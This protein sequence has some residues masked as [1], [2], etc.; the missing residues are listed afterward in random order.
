[1]SATS[2]LL[3]NHTL[4]TTSLVASSPAWRQTDNNWCEVGEVLCAFPPSSGVLCG[5]GTGDMD[6]G[7][8]LEFARRQPG[9]QCELGQGPPSNATTVP[10]GTL[11]A[12]VSSSGT[13]LDDILSGRGTVAM[14][15]VLAGVVIL[16]GV[17]LLVVSGFS[18]SEMC[19]KSEEVIVF[20]PRK[21]EEERDPASHSTGVVRTVIVESL[22]V[23]SGV[24]SL[25]AKPHQATKVLVQADPD[26]LSCSDGA[27]DMTVAS[28]AARARVRAKCKGLSMI[29]SWSSLP[30]LA[31]IGGGLLDEDGDDVELAGVAVQRVQDIATSWSELPATRCIVEDSSAG[32]DPAATPRTRAE[33]IAQ[34]S[35]KLTSLQEGEG[36]RG[37]ASSALERFLGVPQADLAKQS[38]FLDL[39]ARWQ[40]LQAPAVIVG[41]RGGPDAPV[42]PAPSF[43]QRASENGKPPPPPP[44][45]R[46]PSAIPTPPV[47]PTVC[48]RDSTLP[49]VLG[50]RFEPARRGQVPPPPQWRLQNGGAEP[51][52]PPS[53]VRVS[54][55]VRS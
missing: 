36:A 14:W 19:K 51:R 23:M 26:G 40:R 34:V 5:R 47:P 46:N 50:A 17:L 44:P 10:M 49:T 43:A 39:A 35:E 31:R 53:P 4:T 41:L 22:G 2:L 28:S 33:A 42:A 30:E 21:G 32:I 18:F 16:G 12:T 1:M 29:K 52:Q 3:P 6:A 54:A 48:S 27:D 37:K 15:F 13:L 11:E 24:G 20:L 55:Q 9:W 8:L 45:A 25:F 7:S 38:R